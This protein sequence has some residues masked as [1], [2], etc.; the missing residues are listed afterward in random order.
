MERCDV[1]ITV[2]SEKCKRCG[3][4]VAACPEG[5]FGRRD[6][7]DPPETIRRDL[8]ISCGH[9]VALCPNDAIMHTAF[10]EGRVP[11][12]DTR[13]LPST[14]QVL[15]LLRAR[16]SARVFL[17]APV[18]KA[19]LEQ[20]IDAAHLGPSAHNLQ[21]TEFIVVQDKALLRGVTEMTIAFLDRTRK[22]LRNPIIQFLYGLMEGNE[23][24]GALPL[25]PDFDMVVKAFAEGKDPILRG[26]ACL[27]L[28]H[29]NPATSYPDKNAQLALANATI[30]AQALGLGSFYAGYVV[31]AC[32]RDRKIRRLLSIPKGRRVYAGLTLGYPKFKFTR[33]IRRAPAAVVWR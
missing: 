14:A 7:H 3:T 32:E 19:Y 20:V 9:C 26:A 1:K 12:I 21:T 31:G 33:W 23:L 27:V 11:P 6:D 17:D 25:L 15:E 5:V 10:P 4:C 28:F 30:M 16:R 18:P 22:Q 24:R 8:C 13:L 29:A 2:N